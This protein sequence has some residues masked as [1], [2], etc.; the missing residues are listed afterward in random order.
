MDYMLNN[1]N[2]NFTNYWENALNIIYPLKCIFCEKIL[3]IK[4]VDTCCGNCFQ[5]L[6]FIRN[7]YCLKCMGYSK[8]ELYCKTCLNCSRKFEK[9]ISVFSYT[10]I[11][12]AS[13]LRYKIFRKINYSQQYAKFMYDLFLSKYKDINFSLM[14][15]VPTSII[16]ILKRGFDQTDELSKNLNKFIEIPYIKNVLIKNWYSKSQKGLKQDERKMNVFGTIKI[17]KKMNVKDKNILL[18]DDVFTT[19]A[20]FN[21]CAKILL[22]NDARKVYTLSLARAF[23][24]D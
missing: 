10:G 4:S 11:V 7:D 2:D 5:K 14:T 24:K 1:E 19:G 20:T 13:I 23:N 9:N 18:I 22:N 21:E 6:P 3:P 8:K 12:R 15:N 17:N 16:S